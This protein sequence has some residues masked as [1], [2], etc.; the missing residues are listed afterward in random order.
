MVNYES[1]NLTEDHCYNIRRALMYCRE[2]QEDGLIFPKR[3]YHLYPEKASMC[4]VSVSNHD[5]CG[6][7][8]IA[9]LLENMRDF[10]LDGGGSTFISHGVM[11]SVALMDCFNI[12]LRNLEFTVEEPMRMEAEVIGY[13]GKDWIL[14]VTNDV[15]Y[16][17]R[18]GMLRFTDAYGHDDPYHYTMIA[19]RGQGMDYIP[20]TKESFDKNVRFFRMEGKK[21][22][23]QNSQLRPEEGMRLILAPQIRHGCTVFLKNCT[24]TLIEDLVICHSY[25][26]GVVAQLCDTVTI[27]RMKVS[28]DRAMFSTNC[29]ATH[30]V[31]CTGKVEISDSCFESMLDDA[32]NIHGVFTRVEQVDEKGIL[33]HDMHPG[34]K[35]LSLY[36]TGDRIAVM[37]PR[38]LIPES[39]Y[40]VEK[41]EQI[42]ME[43]FYLTLRERADHIPV[44]YTVENI[45]RQPEVIFCNNVVKANRARGILLAS[46][47]RTLVRNNA[48]HT[49]GCAVLFESDGEMWYE[50]GGTRD[51]L[52]ENNLF[53]HCGYAREAWGEAVIEIKPRKEADGIHYYHKQIRIRKNRFTGK[54][55]IILSAADTQEIEFSG[56]EVPENDKGN[57]YYNCG[58]VLDDLSGSGQT[59]E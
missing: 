5:I 53:D 17:I 24:N 16:Y 59:Y 3:E 48:F 4:A 31:S 11:L 28:P 19:R 36:S 14:E 35:G 8:S 18:D 46:K 38:R 27:R 21:I 39:I 29:D 34:S 41:A 45:S 12:R 10:T 33:V 2:N 40:T 25:G 44:M 47:G 37:N 7:N 26:M 15:G 50:S 23:V 56:N 32:M 58:H 22:L 51:V 49:P 54:E 30:F 43:Y 1:F 6:Y 20:E 55:R 52:I 9:F 42:N 57:R 13:S